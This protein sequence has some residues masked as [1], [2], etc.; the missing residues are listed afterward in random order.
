MKGLHDQREQRGQMVCISGLGILLQWDFINDC[1]QANNLQRLDPEVND[2]HKTR[3]ETQEV[4]KLDKLIRQSI[5]TVVQ[6]P[7]HQSLRHIKHD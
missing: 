7:H 2:S 1:M 4:K 3:G 5:Q 6:P